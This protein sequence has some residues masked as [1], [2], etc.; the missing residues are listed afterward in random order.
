MKVSRLKELLK[1]GHELEFEYGGK[2]Y[3]LTWSDLEGESG[4]LSFC[5]FQK[6]DIA[7][8]DID[9]ILDAVYNGQKVAD[10]I[11]AL[12]EKEVEIF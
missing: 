6:E 3:S 4:V 2:K 12:D 11:E 8:S 7:S 10:I 1:D 5:E 9:E